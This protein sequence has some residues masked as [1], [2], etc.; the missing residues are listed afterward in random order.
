MP[1]SVPPPQSSA[2]PVAHLLVVSTPWA[3]NASGVQTFALGPDPIR[4]GASPEADIFLNDPELAGIHARIEIK[5]GDY[6]LVREANPLLANGMRVRIHVLRPNDVIV[7]GRNVL[8]YRK[9]PVAQTSQS[10]SGLEVI[11]RLAAF[12]SHTH[13]GDS[14]T[15][16]AKR[17]LDDVVELT[18]A[19]HGSILRISSE[20][21][22]V[23]LASSERGSF[24]EPETHI[25]RTLL[26]AVRAR[27]AS[28]LVENTLIDPILNTAESIAGGPAF[29]ALCVPIMSE[30]RLIGAFYLSAAPS[31]LGAEATE[32][33]ELYASQAIRLLESERRQ[34]RL[35]AKL[36][37]VGSDDDESPLVGASEKVVALKRDIRKIASSHVPVLVRG[38][39]GTGKELVAREIHRLSM[40]AGEPF[41][42]L[43]CGAIAPELL[44]SEL[45]GHQRGAF[46]GA[47]NAR[48]GVFRSA[49]KGTLFLDEIG[50]MP[51]P[52]QVAL[53]RV[54]QEG[55]VVPVG[56]EKGVAVDV[57]VVCATHRDLEADVR[58]GRFRQDLFFRLGVVRLVLPALRERGGDILHLANLFLRRAAKEQGR[59][60]LRFGEEALVAMRQASWEGN[61]REL[62]GRVRRAALLADDDVIGPHDLELEAP[63]SRPTPSQAPVHVRPLSVARD[64]YLR[65]YVRETVERFQGNRTQ[66][67][68]ALMVNVRTVFKYMDE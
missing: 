11:R 60:G 56:G 18:G 16:L 67:A 63:I 59:L 35:V 48:P 66:A 45:F 58:T 15:I 54:L 53:L 14:D 17:L 27:G 13:D 4:I 23:S 64:E 31:R 57:R 37:M 22:L 46:T 9:G 12:S 1:V 62:E 28:I 21:D 47:V 51:M 3:Q 61:V 36:E 29:S 38:E 7:M 40:R 49:D 2:L 8:C 26:S 34:A 52:Q 50:E 30:G 42:A 5:G 39:T 20:E 32:L 10:K 24:T 55:I 68:E 43:N 6:I 25:S 44:M 33:T 41:V 19:T 65:R